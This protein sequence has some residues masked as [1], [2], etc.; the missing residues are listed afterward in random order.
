MNGINLS[1]AYRIIFIL[2]L[3]NVTNFYFNHLKFYLTINPYLISV[4]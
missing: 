3:K 2:W 1:Y 4:Q